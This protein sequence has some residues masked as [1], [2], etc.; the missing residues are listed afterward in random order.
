[1]P[2]VTRRKSS[3]RCGIAT[4]SRRTCGRCGS[5]GR[6]ER[7]KK[8]GRLAPKSSFRRADA[9]SK[10]GCGKRQGTDRSARQHNSA[11]LTA[12]ARR[13]RAHYTARGRGAKQ[14]TVTGPLRRSSFFGSCARIGRL[15]SWL[16]PRRSPIDAGF[17]TC[18][19]TAFPFRSG[20]WGCD[21]APPFFFFR[22]AH[23]RPLAPAC[24]STGRAARGGSTGDPV[25][26]T[27][28]EGIWNGAPPSRVGRR[29]RFE[30]SVVS[31][32]LNIR[33]KSFAAWR[34]TN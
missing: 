2:H 3:D 16:E 27:K 25:D 5:C 9:R 29:S 30:R 1:M 10:A 20:G 4:S 34:F 28:K 22:W 24:G 12:T 11:K 17:R 8:R 19:G 7:E 18:I 13:L 14:A 26:R 31:P 21:R 23:V 33:P 6:F 32:L 15:A